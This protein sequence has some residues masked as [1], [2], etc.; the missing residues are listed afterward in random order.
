MKRFY[1]FLC[2]S[3]CVALGFFGFS[4]SVYAFEPEEVHCFSA[5]VGAG[6]TDG[7]YR[8]EAEGQSCNWIVGAIK[9]GPHSWCM[10][11]LEEQ[12]D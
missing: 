3:M 6:P 4:E 8:C 10:G 7:Y 1:V 11:P 5:Q 9:F 12:I 2:I